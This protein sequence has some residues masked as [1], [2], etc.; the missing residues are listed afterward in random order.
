VGLTRVPRPGV[1]RPTT[2]L[3]LCISAPL[4]NRA[5]LLGSTGCARVRPG[6]ATPLG[7]VRGVRG[8][9]DPGVGAGDIATDPGAAA[10][11]GVKGGRSGDASFLSG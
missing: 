4:L 7:V 6:V 8:L 10:R 3:R 2:G 9:V 5:P 1:Y 11:L